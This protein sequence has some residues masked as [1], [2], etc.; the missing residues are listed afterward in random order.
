MD[1]VEPGA[2]T[3]QS[4]TISEWNKRLFEYF[5]SISVEGD[6]PVTRLV[7]T[8]EELQRVVGNDAISQDDVRDI[9]LKAIRVRL[10]AEKKLLWDA[11]NLERHHTERYAIP[12]FFAHLV[13]TCLA[14]SYADD[15]GRAQGN[16]FRKW[17]NTLL[18][19]A[20]EDPNYPLYDLP[21]LWGKLV[22]WL[23]EA[24]RRGESYR[25][26]VLPKPGRMRLIGY[27]VNLAFPPRKDQ[28]HLIKLLADQ[29]FDSNPPVLAV[30]E[31]I[32]KS[33][34]NN[35]GAF[36]ETFYQAFEEFWRDYEARD[37]ELSQLYRRA[38]WS[39]VRDAVRRSPPPRGAVVERGTAQALLRLDH[40]ENWQFHLTLQVDSDCVNDLESG[41]HAESTEFPVDGFGYVLYVGN[42]ADPQNYAVQ[43]LLDN[44]LRKAIPPLRAPEL[45]RAVSE[46]VL[47]FTPDETGIYI[48][49][50]SR[51]EGDDIC[52]L[53]REDLTES[54]LTALSGGHSDRN[55]SAESLY[56][57]WYEVWELSGAQLASIDFTKIPSLCHIQSLQEVLLPRRI[58]LR[59]GVK[60][61]SGW[62]GLRDCLP[63]VIA[64]W[65]ERVTV[66]RMTGMM[67]GESV[68]EAVP[69]TQASDRSYW[70]FPWPSQFPEDLEGEYI[71]VA[72]RGESAVPRRIVFRS[73]LTGSDYVPPSQPELWLDMDAPTAECGLLGEV[74]QAA[75]AATFHVSVG[76]IRV[77]PDACAIVIE[78]SED[79]V[80][81]VERLTEILAA[82]SYRRQGI[83]T[84]ELYAWT[85]QVLGVRGR[86]AW[87]V[88]RAWVEIGCLDCFTNRR[89]RMQRYFARRPHLVAYRLGT[90]TQ[91]TATLQGLAPRVVRQHLERVAR[92]AGVVVEQRQSAS[93]WV[94]SLLVLRAGSTKVLEEISRDADLGQLRWLQSIDGC[95][96]PIAQVAESRPMD[97]LSNHVLA[98]Y[99]NWEEARFKRANSTQAEDAVTL[100][101]YRRGNAPDG[102][103]VRKGDWVWHTH[104]RTWAL[105]V[106][107]LMRS[108]QPFKCT[109][110]YALRRQR[111]NGAHL[112][113]TVGRLAAVLGP[114][115]PGPTPTARDDHDY[116]YTFPTQA[117]RDYVHHTLWPS[118]IPE[119]VVH[120]ARWLMAVLKARS[121]LGTD[122]LAPVPYRLR[123]PLRRLHAIPTLAGLAKITHVPHHLLPHLT[124]LADS[125]MHTCTDTSP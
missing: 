86:L 85:Q 95:V 83:D 123:L 6:E 35:S 33:I 125:L 20:P 36:S 40:D 50:A 67:S 37:T 84:G 26:L 77:W 9:F 87:D 52:A 27:S 17:L 19:R 80:R 78:T 72:Y 4:W 113:L 74:T 115:S 100:E 119:T 71:L 60:V 99:W 64:A 109:G 70:R 41:V 59:G 112:P 14:A 11:F 57:G 103:V 30:L 45:F 53:I 89:W 90:G 29:G 56:P 63:N 10:K 24:R 114:I 81:R 65:A 42:D 12:P 44:Q 58:S 96:I 34:K 118:S 97:L 3:L 76:P 22:S 75:E 54:F 15:D 108:E 73:A 98:G 8:P 55:P 23:D 31:I 38:F 79:E 68:A 43:L 104:S 69:L 62:L 51:P 32:G 28:A 105:L 91:I 18:G 102:Y 2:E 5:F 94:P 47:L 7:V 21:E 110:E 106:G 49:T 39:A 13:L 122:I 93:P 107:F 116:V 101:W 92:G 124:A 16:N 88:I 46:G 1:A 25:E 121:P 111:P 117:I 120:R 66:Q 61:D 82:L 48:F